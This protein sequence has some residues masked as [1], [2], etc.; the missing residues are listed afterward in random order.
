MKKTSAGLVLRIIAVV[1]VAVFAIAVLSY[2]FSVDF[3][4]PDLLKKPD[5]TVREMP[6]IYEEEVKNL[7][8]IEVDWVSGPVTL[9]FYE[10]DVL[11]ITETAKKEIGK[12]EKLYLELSGSTLSVKWNSSL[13]QLGLFR[14]DSKQL[15]LLIPQA[16]FEKLESVQISTVSGDIGIDGLT[17]EDAKFET[18]SGEL[19]LSNITAERFSAKTTS[20]D[21][22]CQNV[23]GTEQITV[24]STSGEKKLSG[25]TG[26]EVKLD[27][28]SGETTLDGT[29]DTLACTSV[30]GGI[31]LD[32]H[33]WP[34]ETSVESV[35]GDIELYA[36]DVKGGFI[37]SVSTVSGDFDCG[38]DAKKSGKLYQHG[39]G[40]NVLKISTT[41]GDA[42]LHEKVG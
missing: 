8:G 2:G 24:S 22:F 7:R 36:P 1:C 19:H 6:Y 41:S 27:N 3:G 11:R 23:T 4:I 34:K 35:S 26:G 37:C 10:G 21:I 12:D 29:A 16:F 15:E 28:T 25:I 14:D 38:F 32:L 20:G 13:L 18:T 31:K 40:E 9:K 33:A 39:K 42:E 30:S 5:D 17:A